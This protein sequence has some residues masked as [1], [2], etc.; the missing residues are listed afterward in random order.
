[1][2][3]SSGRKKNARNRRGFSFRKVFAS[4]IH[5]TVSF[6]IFGADSLLML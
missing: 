6:V 1:M 2:L 4:C 3:L 5:V